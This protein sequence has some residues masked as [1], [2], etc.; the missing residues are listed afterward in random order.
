MTRSQR[1]TR[2]GPIDL[3]G[4]G[5]RAPVDHALEAT[6]AMRKA[7]GWPPNAQ[8]TGDQWAKGFRAINHIQQALVGERVVQLSEAADQCFIRNHGQLEQVYAQIQPALVGVDQIIGRILQSAG[9]HPRCDDDAECS[10]CGRVEAALLI[11]IAAG[12]LE[13][14]ADPEAPEQVP[15]PTVE[16]S[17]EAEPVEAQG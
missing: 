1:R 5:R 11:G 12:L 4:L 6:I 9:N 15:V 10:T 8:P 13:P 17:P 2:T 16:P 14:T 7:G 3:G